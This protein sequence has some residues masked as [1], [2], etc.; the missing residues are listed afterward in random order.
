MGVTL[1]GLISK[2]KGLER[3]VAIKKEVR[4]HFKQN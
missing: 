3:G 4:S 2:V 1:D